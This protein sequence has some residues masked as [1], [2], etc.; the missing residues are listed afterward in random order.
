M[1]QILALTDGQWA[2]AAA[3]LVALVAALASIASA[4]IGLAAKKSHEERIGTPNG[5]GTIAEMMAK[6]LD[7]Q[8]GQDTRLAVIEQ[9]QVSQAERLTKIEHTQQTFC[10]SVHGLTGAIEAH[11]DAPQPPGN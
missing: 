8:T 1:S 5:H 3:V 7:G 11:V 9:R 2:A 4:L 10:A 6:L